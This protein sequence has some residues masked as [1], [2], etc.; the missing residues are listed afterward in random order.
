MLSLGI[1]DMPILSV[2]SLLTDTQTLSF[3]S[4]SELSKKGLLVLV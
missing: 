3:D 4:S 1:G 2:T